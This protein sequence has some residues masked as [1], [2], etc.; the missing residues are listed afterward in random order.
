MNA[1][2]RDFAK[3]GRLYAN[4]GNWNGN[5]SFLN[6]VTE[7]TKVDNSEGSMRGI[8]TNGGWPQ[9]K[10]YMAQGILGQYIYINPNKNLIIVRLGKIM[11][12]YLDLI[13]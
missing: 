7:S 6:W 11:G 4:Y 3:I 12:M 9:R 1:R 8:T 5:K 10:A 13:Y 2:A